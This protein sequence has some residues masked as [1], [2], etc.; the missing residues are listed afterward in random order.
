M[1]ERMLDKTHQPTEEEIEQ[2]VGKDAWADLLLIKETLKSLFDLTLE[3]K[4]PFGNSYG[5]SYK[6]S[7]K[8]KH[9]FYLFFER[10]SLT[11]TV[12]IPEPKTERERELIRRLSEKGKKYWDTKYPC[13][14][15]GWVH[16]RFSR[17]DELPDAGLFISLRTKKNVSFDS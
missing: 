5:W 10:G 14:S 17:A 6:F 1:N 9:L 12:Q 16:Y 8:K 15:G 4:F 7:N 3:L 13:G 2:F 11:L